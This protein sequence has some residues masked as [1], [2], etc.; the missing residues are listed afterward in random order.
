MEFK[1]KFGNRKKSKPQ[2]GLLLVGLLI[3]VIFLWYK[4]ESFMNLLF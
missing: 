4:A 2:K 1:K 3:L